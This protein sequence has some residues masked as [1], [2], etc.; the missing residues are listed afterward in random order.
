M[1]L[2]GS[3]NRTKATM[4]GPDSNPVYDEACSRAALLDVGAERRGDEQGVIGLSAKAD[5]LADNGSHGGGRVIGIK[6]PGMCTG[7]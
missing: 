5:V 1:A 7:S 4:A 6:K 2:G 3:G